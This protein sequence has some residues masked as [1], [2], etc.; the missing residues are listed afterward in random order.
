MVGIPQVG[1]T[2][3]LYMYMYLGT[4]SSRDPYLGTCTYVQMWDPTSN[5]VFVMVALHPN[6]HSVMQVAM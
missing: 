5:Q 3:H 1:F 4:T 2:V 6:S